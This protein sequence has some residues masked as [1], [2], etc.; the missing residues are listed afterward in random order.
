M[1]FNAFKEIQNSSRSLEDFEEFESNL[2]R[3][4]TILAGNCD[5]GDESKSVP[6]L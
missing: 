5:G 1:D 3:L 6:S 2:N 4:S